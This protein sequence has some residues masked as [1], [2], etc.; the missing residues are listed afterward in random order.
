MIAAIYIAQYGSLDNFQP[1]IDQYIIQPPPFIPLPGSPTICPKGILLFTR[2]E[3]PKRVLKPALYQQ[4]L[5]CLPL[6][7]SKAGLTLVCLRT[8]Q[9]NILIRNVHVPTKDHRLVLLQLGNVLQEAL[10][11]LE[12]VVQS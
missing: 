2:V 10:L 1:V 3:L 8:S 7:F 6:L 5:E 12:A 4:F 11:V 9:V